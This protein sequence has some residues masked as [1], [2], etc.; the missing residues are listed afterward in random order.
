MATLPEETPLER[1]DTK[2]LE[3]QVKRVEGLLKAR[4]LKLE[5]H[6]A[7]QDELLAQRLEHL[8]AQ[9]GDHEIRLRANTEGVTQFKIFSGLASGG[10]GIMSLV[11]IIKA[12]IGG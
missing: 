7:H 5:A 2:L 3:S 8:E 6:V 10:S 12:F 11:A 9:I 4:I 1:V